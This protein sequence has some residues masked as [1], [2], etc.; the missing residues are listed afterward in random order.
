MYSQGI[1]KCPEYSKLGHS[2]E[3]ALH[4]SVFSEHDLQ[5]VRN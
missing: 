1:K 4:G 5:V 2:I 3:N